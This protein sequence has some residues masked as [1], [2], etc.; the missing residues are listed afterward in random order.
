MSEETQEQTSGWFKWW[1]LLPVVL[2]VGLAAIFYKGFD[3]TREL[4]SVLI[5]K[6]APMKSLGP[7][8]G[9]VIDGKQ[10]PGFDAESMKKGKVTVVNFF[11]SWC[12]TCRQEH[13]Q[14]VA[15]GQMKG[16]NLVGVNYKDKPGDA[17]RFL[18]EGGSP[19]NVIGADENGRVGIEWGVV[20]LPETYLVDGKGVIRYKFIGAIS[21]A[22]LEREFLPKL[23]ELMDEK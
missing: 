12:V 22:A 6:P 8:K 5:G 23:Q 14:L 21:R 16:F 1:A 10:V 9:L 7:V 18:N 4:P 17:I 13:P 11:A 2:F 20:G 15:L 3:H 19:Y